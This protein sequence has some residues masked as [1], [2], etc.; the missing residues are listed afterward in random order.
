M[1]NS[2]NR[3]DYTGTC[4]TPDGKEY[5][6]AL[7]KGETMGG[8]PKMSLKL[9][10]PQEKLT[11]EHKEGSGTVFP[12]NND[13]PSSSSNESKSDGKDPDLPF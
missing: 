3:P 2:N 11:Y 5:N 13:E 1:S 12:N 9:S 4:K 8:K 7:W 6:V 10:V